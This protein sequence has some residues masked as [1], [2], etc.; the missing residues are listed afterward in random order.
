M[1]LQSESVCSDDTGNK[2]AILFLYPSEHV[3][4]TRMTK[5]DMWLPQVREKK[6]EITL[7]G[8]ELP[9]CVL[10]HKVSLWYLMVF[11]SF[12]GIAF[13]AVPAETGAQT[14]GVDIIVWFGFILTA[15]KLYSHEY[16]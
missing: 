11:L 8:V 16:T 12:Y 3:P 14:A 1:A 10:F 7:P 2:S 5:P 13:I 9:H 15:F 6:R 4:K